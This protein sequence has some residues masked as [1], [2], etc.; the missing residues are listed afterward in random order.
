[1]RRVPERLF[2]ALLLLLSA[3]AAAAE[4][5]TL[6]HT[7]DE[8]ARLDRLRRGETPATAASTASAN[9]EVTGYVQRSDGRSTVWIDG[10]AVPVA[11]PRAQPLFDPK[12][13]RAYADRKDQDLKIERK[14]AR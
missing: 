4:L 14:Q 3:H 12:S 8:R 2:A 13:V 9:P 7:P 6:F 10:V 5:G 1:V 11:T